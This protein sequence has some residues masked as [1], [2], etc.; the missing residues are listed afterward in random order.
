[1]VRSSRLLVG[2]TV[3]TSVKFTLSVETWILYCDAYA[4]SQLISTVS[5]FRAVPRS[6]CHHS[7]SA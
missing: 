7:L 2:L 6:T 1:V 5:T 4:L 3:A